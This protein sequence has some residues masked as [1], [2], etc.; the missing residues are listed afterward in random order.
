MLTVFEKRHRF[1]L[2]TSFWLSPGAVHASGQIGVRAV[3]GA[4]AAPHVSPV[5][6]ALSESLS[7]AQVLASRSVS[8]HG[9]CPA[10]LP[11][12]LARYRNMP[13]SE[14]VEALSPGN[15]RRRCAQHA[16]R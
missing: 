5:R 10:H 14:R 4:L 16:R 8:V 2:A 1:Q 11:R 13:A 9:V 7:D 12:E 6:G 3:D 15:P